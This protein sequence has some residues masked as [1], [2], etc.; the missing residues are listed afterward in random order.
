MPKPLPQ[1]HIQPLTGWLNDPNGV[2]RRD[3]RWHVFYQANPLAP[4]HRDIE[5]GHVSSEDLVSWQHHPAAFRPTPG[6]P[7]SGGC[8]SGVYLPWL[9]RPAV[10]YSGLVTG[11]DD[12]TVCV[13]EALDADLIRWSAPTAVASAPEVARVMRDPFCFTWGTR[14]LAVIGAQL[15]TGEAAVLLYDVA[16][17]GAWE[18]LGVWLHSGQLDIDVPA[19]DIWECPQLIVNG[20][21][22]WLVV[23][24][25][26]AGVTL[27]VIGLSGRVEDRDGLPVLKVG[28]VERLDDGDAFY[29]PQV[30]LDG[31][32]PPLLFGWIREHDEEAAAAT[33]VS[34]CLTLP[35]RV[36]TSGPRLRFA[37]DGGLQRYADS[38]PAIPVPLAAGAIA[39][40][41]ALARV[42]G[43]ASSVRL[44]GDRQSTE[45]ACPGGVFELWLDGEVAE[46]FPADAPPVTL[47]DSGTARWRIVVDA[48]TTLTV[49]ELVPPQSPAAPMA[50]AT[51]AES[52]G[53]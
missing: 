16:D 32:N 9:A 30:A 46:L 15:T 40:L 44:V 45:V 3:G 13:R 23:S 21:R 42:R 47:R 1:L 24:R 41:P 6:G 18:F 43:T 48:A 31:D 37:V 29:A 53:A 39:E 33:G 8:W 19:A 17:P 51:A 25:W 34:G 4:V 27:D 11:E 2:V 5:W 35:R 10:A 28:G 7:D 38:F 22:C 36:D 20:D 50:R 52:S 12:T 49:C 14:R 26:V